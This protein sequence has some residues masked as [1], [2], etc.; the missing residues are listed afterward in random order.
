MKIRSNDALTQLTK[1]K[2]AIYSLLY[3][4]QGSSPYSNYDSNIAYDENDSEERLLE[5]EI[6]KILEKLDYI[7]GDIKYLTS[8]IKDE[9]YLSK[10]TNGRY[11]LNGYE[12]TCGNG[13]EVLLY[14]EW[15]ERFDWS[16]TRIE[17]D[18]NDYYAV[19]H[20]DICLDGVKA[21]RRDIR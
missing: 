19:G 8:S 9:G 18:G 16:I 21:R 17:H 7:H 14:D 1:V 4:T 5:N 15:S 20:S 12:Y 6:N 13:I 10:N 11:E 2:E 3:V